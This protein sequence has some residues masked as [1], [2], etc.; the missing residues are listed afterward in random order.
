MS[1]GQ[2]EVL[3]VDDQ[4]VILMLI[5]EVLSGAGFRVLAASDGRA[6]LERAR[7]R[8]PAAIVLD[9][10]MPEMD[11][12]QV[13]AALREDARTAAIPVILTSASPDPSFPLR[14]RE[15]GVHFL[16][17]PFYWRTLVDVVGAAARE[18]RPVE[19]G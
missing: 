19:V 18:G 6:A 14:A 2:P 9:I 8:P 3:V 11:G 12:W 15:A 13:L 7:T 4:E 1:S 16:A 17:K 10:M 5:E